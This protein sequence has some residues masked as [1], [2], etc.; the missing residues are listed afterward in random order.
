MRYAWFFLAGL[1][2]LTMLWTMKWVRA[3]LSIPEFD[4]SVHFIDPTHYQG[5]NEQV[6][7]LLN[8]IAAKAEANCVYRRCSAKGFR[9]SFVTPEAQS[10]CVYRRCGAE[11]IHRRARLDVQAFKQSLKV[12]D[13]DLLCRIIE[14]QCKD[15]SQPV[16]SYRRIM[17][18]Y[19]H[20]IALS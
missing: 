11:E 20:D 8:F 6:V 5:T 4:T 19:R 10:G 13:R 16:C 7:E 17:D 9:L 2:L 3:E 18:I 15:E 12:H 14:R 1:L